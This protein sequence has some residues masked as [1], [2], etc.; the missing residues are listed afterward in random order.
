MHSH[1]RNTRHFPINIKHSPPFPGYLVNQLVTA[2]L[3]SVNK[4]N[5]TFKSNVS[6]TLSTICNNETVKP[7]DISMLEVKGY[8]D[9]LAT[10]EEDV[11]PEPGQHQ[12][13]KGDG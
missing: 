4:S 8:I 5:F 9:L 12:H 7:T 11:E 2:R 3:S 6:T 13:D 1:V 10:Q